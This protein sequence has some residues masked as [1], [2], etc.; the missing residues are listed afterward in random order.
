MVSA[1]LSLALSLSLSHLTNFF[2]ESCAKEVE[3]YVQKNGRKEKKETLSSSNIA[4][5]EIE[6]PPNNAL[7]RNRSLAGCREALSTT[8]SYCRP[9]DGNT[10]LRIGCP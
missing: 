9:W 3:S 8:S 2:A 5:N 7:I 1:S 4:T 10:T 6:F